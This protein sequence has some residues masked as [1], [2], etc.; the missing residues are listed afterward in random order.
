MKDVQE[1]IV[2]G[3]TH[4]QHPSFFA[5]FPANMS[6]PSL[7]GDMMG[8]MFNIIGFSWITSPAC[9]ELETIVLEW[10][11]KALQ[12]PESFSS[13]GKGGGVI[14]QTASEATL[15]AL[16][17]AKSRFIKEGSKLEELSFYMSDQSHSSV[18]KACMIAGIDSKNIRMIESNEMF[19]LCPKKLQETIENDL[20]DNLKPCFLVATIGTT[21]SCAV[22]DVK[23][24]GQI[25]QKYNIWM[26]IDSAYAGSAMICPE[27]RHHLDGVEYAYSFNF[28]PHKWMLTNFDC[29]T[30]W[31]QDRSLLIN[32]FDISP[33]YLRN[34]ASESGLVIDYRN[35]Q[36]PLG[37][38]FRSLKLWFVLRTYG[39]EGIQEYIRYVS[40]SILILAFKACRVIRKLTSQRQEV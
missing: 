21:S 13:V 12:L 32:A 16:L 8:A 37:R 17:A 26:H 31:I 1:F 14:Q 28:N 18:Q 25:C 3:V 4:W 24:I 5:Y 20:K 29:S 38:R 30:M 2:P 39:I 10:L 6:Y 15:V 19:Q 27:L 40:I 34:K 7:L 35:W 23:T 33:E 9:T 22:D 11:R 36:I